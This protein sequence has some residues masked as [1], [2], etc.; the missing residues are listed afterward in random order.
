MVAV[1][2]AGLVRQL[3]SF[4][5]IPD[6][7]L[8]NK[9]RLALIL[10]SY[11]THVDIRYTRQQSSY[12]GVNFIYFFSNISQPIR[13]TCAVHHFTLTYCWHYHLAPDYLRL[14]WNARRLAVCAGPVLLWQYRILQVKS[15]VGMLFD[16]KKLFSTII[17][18]NGSLCS[19]DSI[20]ILLTRGFPCIPP[21]NL[22]N[23]LFYFLGVFLAVN[24]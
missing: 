18:C 14:H 12:S 6:P 3:L 17:I 5:S 1:G 13:I 2:F 19:L 11:G 20:T 10:L 16:F 9:H 23:A 21:L 22:H 7:R 4:G 15:K 24:Y 8:I